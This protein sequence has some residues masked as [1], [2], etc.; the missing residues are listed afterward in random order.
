M[1]A[2]DRIRVFTIYGDTR[3]FTVEEFRY[4]L[5][6]FTSE[7][8]RIAGKF[9]PLCELY[10]RGPESEDYSTPRYGKYYTNPVQAWMDIPREEI[11]NDNH[12]PESHKHHERD[13]L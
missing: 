12:R 6:V 8:H 7:Q 1:K 9:M 2:G 10:E 5:G 4:C 11:K 13:H 3:D